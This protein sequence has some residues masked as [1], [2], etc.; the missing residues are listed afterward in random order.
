[1]SHGST[2]VATPDDEVQLLGEHCII[3]DDEERGVGR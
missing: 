3:L 1:M 2:Q